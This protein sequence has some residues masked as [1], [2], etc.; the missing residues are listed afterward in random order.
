MSHRLQITLDDRQY[1]V[2]VVESSRTGASIAA[3]VRQTLDARFGLESVDDRNRRFRSAVR[4]AAGVWSDR[5][6]DGMAYQRRVRAA[7]TTRNVEPARRKR[8]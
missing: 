4:G 5:V 1:E 2:L 7:L 8:G 3:L 6:D